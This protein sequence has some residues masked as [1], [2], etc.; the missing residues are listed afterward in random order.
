MAACL[1]VFHVRE[2]SQM[3][4]KMEIFSTFLSILT[5]VSNLII[6]HQK[7]EIESV[8]IPFVVDLSTSQ[9]PLLVLFLVFDPFLIPNPVWY[10]A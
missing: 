3:V 4:W 10:M 6:C 8:T 9:L 1:L 5:Y 7:V 2:M